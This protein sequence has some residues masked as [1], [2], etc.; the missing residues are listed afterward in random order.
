MKKILLCLFTMTSVGL[1]STLAQS[2][3]VLPPGPLEYTPTYTTQRWLQRLVS[4]GPNALWGQVQQALQT[5]P[6]NRTY[7]TWIFNTADNGQSW[8][9]ADFAP[10]DL[11][12]IDGQNAWLLNEGKLLRTTSGVTGFTQLPA[13]LPTAFKSIHFF[14]ATTGIAL[15]TT[16]KDATVWPIY[17]TTDGGLSWALVA[18]LPGR[19]G[20]PTQFDVKSYIKKKLDNHF[21]LTAGSTMLHTMD[22]GL[23]WTVASTP[24]QAYFSDPLNG[25]S[26]YSTESGTATVHHL[27][28]TTDGGASWSEIA[29]TGPT[30]MFSIP[31]LYTMTAVPGSPGTYLYYDYRFL[32]ASNLA[33]GRLIISRDGGSSWQLLGSSF[34]SGAIQGLLPLSPT[35]LWAG[36]NGETG[37]SSE[38]V[39]MRYGGTILASNT[40]STLPAPLAAY[41]NPTSAQVQLTGTFSGTEQA[42]VYDATGRLCQQQPVSGSQSTLDLS[43]QPAGLYQIKVTA[44]NGAVRHLRVSKVQ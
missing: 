25:L 42:R 5:G 8:Q 3:W 4:P 34:T 9:K 27:S 6:G 38:P 36:M 16:P 33:T 44:T 2:P 22:E 10:T 31:G 40:A 13:V 11:A 19:S 20:P 43:R 1:Q 28:R 41:P 18:N 21:W 35:E 24:G 26:Y 14:N 30:N 29:Y 37:L 7:Q 23:T 15:P 39:V 12:A 17:R 32:S